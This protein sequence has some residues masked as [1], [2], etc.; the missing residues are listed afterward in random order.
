MSFAGWMVDTT[1]NY[2]AAFLL[3][4]FS[5]IFCAFLLAFA[6]LIKKLKRKKLTMTVPTSDTKQEIWTNGDLTSAANE[7]CNHKEV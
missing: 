4:G 2:T 5:M 1:G 3:S 6:K 7:E